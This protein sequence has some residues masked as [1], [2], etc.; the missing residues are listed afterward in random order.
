MS[1]VLDAYALAVYFEKEPGYE[2]VQTLLAHA[3]S[4][5]HP[6]YISAVNWGEVYYVTHRVHGR[7]AAEQVARVIETFPIEVV[8]VDLAMA[9][10][11][12]V[13]KATHKLSYADC[14]AAALAKLKRATLLT[15]D[16][17]FKS[18]ESEIKILWLK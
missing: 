3:A 7:D 15:G 2:Q 14:F 8:P 4:T 12:A 17:E 9:R 1:Q 13:Y 5:G 18:L 16:R 10:Q 6:L 11:A